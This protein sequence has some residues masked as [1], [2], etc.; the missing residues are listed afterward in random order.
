VWNAP[1]PQEA[2]AFMLEESEEEVEETVEEQV[3]L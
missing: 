2:L 1:V 3:A